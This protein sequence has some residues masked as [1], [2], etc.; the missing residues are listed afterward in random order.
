MADSN[1]ITDNSV[2]T[3][4][5]LLDG[6]PVRQFVVTLT[7]DAGFVGVYEPPRVVRSKD[8]RFK[9]PLMGKGARDVIIAGRGFARHVI[10]RGEIEERHTPNLGDIAVEQ[11]DTIQGS[12]LDST[13]AP[14]ANARV[15][16]ISTPTM[17]SEEPKDELRQLSIGNIVAITDDRG[18]YILEG[19]APNVRRGGHAPEIR[20]WSSDQAS[21]PVPMPYGNATLDLKVAPT[22][23]IEV[24]ANGPAESFIWVRPA[25]DPKT[26][27]RPRRTGF[28][29]TGTTTFDQVPVGDYIVELVTVQR[30]V[31]LQ[32]VGSQRITVTAGT[33]VSVTLTQPAKAQ[34]P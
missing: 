13:G 34:P 2:I 11:G 4:R 9:L 26:L 5:V 24:A 23:V 21:L 7:A 20:A 25:S 22:G 10:L 16:L 1:V 6:Q 31:G 8:G 33:T 29:G 30:G 12:V 27:L 15:A 32:V 28:T 3:G 18:K 14:V 19:V 17:F